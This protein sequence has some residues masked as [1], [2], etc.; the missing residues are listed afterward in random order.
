MKNTIQKSALSTKLIALVFVLCGVQLHAQDDDATLINVTNLDQLDAIR[1]D[2]DGNGTVDNGANAA[3]YKTAFPLA[4]DAGVIIPPLGVTFAGY[5]LMND[6]DFKNGSTNT[7]DFSIWA[8][9]STATGAIDLGGVG[10]DPIG[11]Y[12]NSRD[13]SPFSAIFEGNGHRVS[14]LYINRT[15][16]NVGLFEYVSPGSAKLRN[17]GLLE[18]KVTGGLRLGPLV[19]INRGDISGSYATGSVTG[20]NPV[21]GLVGINVGNIS[22]SYAT[23]AVTGNSFLGGLVGSNEGDI[24]NSYATGTVTGT[25]ASSS[26]VGGLV[27][28]NY[29][30]TV[31]GSYATG[32]VTGNEDVGGLVGENFLG[33]I[34][35]SYYNSE[36]TGQ[37]DVGKGEGKTTAE[38]LTSTDYT[39]IYLTWDDDS[40][41]DWDFGTN[42]QY[43]VLKIDVNGDGTAD[44]D[45]LTLQRSRLS[46]DLTNLDFVADGEGKDFIITS[47]VDWTAEV[48]VGDSWLTLSSG[49]GNGNMTITATVQE[50]LGTER[51]ATITITSGTLTQTINV[52]QGAGTQT[53]LLA[54]P[55][56]SASMRVYPNPTSGQLRFTGLSSD[57]RYTYGLY[58]LVAHK[59]R[60]GQISGGEHIDLGDDF[61]EGQYI[62]VLQTEEGREL[63]RSRVQVVK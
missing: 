8:E 27:G 7:A 38:L 19:G 31:L 62:L 53:V 29:Q 48:S 61:L 63:L 20:T 50:N 18:V 34:T 14:N 10:W 4:T 36:T 9:G 15:S 21:G 23:V 51:M 28:Q 25:L 16:N 22:G 52:T 33:T 60:S 55:V 44:D 56:I 2:L 43:P 39:G 26:H 13:N 6:L 3:T 11:Y 47:N 24:S 58:S 1:Y 46:V 37:S 30:G 40:T 45:D 12:N 59:I 49:S 54:V 41:D 42:L 5:E 32:S 17:I 35:A 57:Q